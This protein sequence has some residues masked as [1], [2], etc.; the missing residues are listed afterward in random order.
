M[1]L[2]RAVNLLGQEDEELLVAAAS[3]IQKHCYSS[4]EAKK[5]VRYTMLYTLF[6]A[7]HVSLDPSETSL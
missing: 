3:F 4:Q 7:V 1:T 6:Y 5:M 2:E